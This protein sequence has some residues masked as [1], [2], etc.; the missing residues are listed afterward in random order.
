MG[1]DASSEGP[2]DIM[3]FTR[4]H[5]EVLTIVLTYCSLSPVM[6]YLIECQSKQ[7]QRP[8]RQPV[9]LYDCAHLEGGGAQFDGHEDVGG[10][11]E[12]HGVREEEARKEV[13]AEEVTGGQRGSHHTVRYQQGRRHG[14][15]YP[16]LQGYGVSQI[17]LLVECEL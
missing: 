10:S 16:P 11:A 1:K 12:E 3:Y 15:V 2:V 7:T 17:V 13:V 4:Y 8:R 9:V 5:H 6:K 14:C